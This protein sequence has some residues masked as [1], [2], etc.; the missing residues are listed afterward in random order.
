M[1]AVT[2]IG[3]VDGGNVGCVDNEAVMQRVSDAKCK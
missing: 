1:S 2:T 3:S